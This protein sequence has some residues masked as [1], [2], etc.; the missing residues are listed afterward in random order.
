MEIKQSI[1][2]YTTESRK[3]EGTALALLA[4]VTPVMLALLQTSGQ[5]E[6]FFIGGFIIDIAVG[7][8]NDFW[9][10]SEEVAWLEAELEVVERLVD[11]FSGYSGVWL[12]DGDGNE[13]DVDDLAHPNA[14][15]G[16]MDCIIIVDA[17]EY[18][19]L[20][21]KR[22]CTEVKNIVINGDY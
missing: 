3:K 8:W 11:R 6:F 14:P 10:D 15:D 4:M 1:L 5:G 12:E 9:D 13:I 19:D 16:G 18:T 20:G 17:D 22:M 2:G 21:F 7:L